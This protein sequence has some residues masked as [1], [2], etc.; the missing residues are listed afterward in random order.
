MPAPCALHALLDHYLDVKLPDFSCT[1]QW[2]TYSKTGDRN[3]SVLGS[4]SRDDEP[5]Y[6]TTPE[7][8]TLFQV[9]SESATVSQ[10]Y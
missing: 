7:Q 5:Q 1:A 6:L 2:T 9:G 3:T 8:D 4:L 10:V